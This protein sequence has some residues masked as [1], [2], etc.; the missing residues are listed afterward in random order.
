[1]PKS[2]LSILEKAKKSSNGSLTI[3]RQMTDEE[4][5][6]ALEQQNRIP[7]PD[8]EDDDPLPVMYTEEIVGRLDGIDI[9]D[10]GAKFRKILV[11][12]L[13]RGVSELEQVDEDLLSYKDLRSWAKWI[14]EFEAKQNELMRLLGAANRF[15]VRSN[16]EQLTQ[17]MSEPNDLK[18]L[19]GAINSID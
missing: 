5:E 3:D 7:N 11:H 14:S 10:E 12:D 18:K 17:F 16:L 19:R 2:I 13:E 15:F 8:S 9:L 4:V 1:M 6:L